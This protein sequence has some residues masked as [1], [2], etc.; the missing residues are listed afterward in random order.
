MYLRELR[1]R[2]LLSLFLVM[3]SASLPAQ[4]QGQ[5]EWLRIRDQLA[6]VMFC[7]L[8][9]KMPDVKPRLYDFDIEQCDLAAQ[10]MADIIA[11]YPERDQAELRAQSKQ[12]AYHLV[13]NAA[14]P[15][16][17]VAACRVYCLDVTKD[18]DTLHD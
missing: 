9:Y 1:F 17:S 6:Q 13:H 5:P 12:H 15:Y 7:Q 2:T 8:I 16:L 18:Q 4:D 10:S 11:R 14:D 3:A